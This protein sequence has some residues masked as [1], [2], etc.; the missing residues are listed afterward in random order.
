MEIVNQRSS[1]ILNLDF[2]GPDCQPVVPSDGEYRID[3]WC[4]NTQILDWTPIDSTSSIDTILITPDQNDFIN[5]D[6]IKEVRLVT[7]K[8]L[9]DE[10]QEA[11]QNY[12]Y[13]VVKTERLK[14][15]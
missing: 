7:V 12:W 13:T 8:F 11:T 9:Y 14:A 5:P 2:T 3:D 6:A 10:G 1:F 4:S 15:S